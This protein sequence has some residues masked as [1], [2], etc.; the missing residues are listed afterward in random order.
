MTFPTSRQAEDVENL[1]ETLDSMLS[2]ML[3]KLDEW[4]AQVDLDSATGGRVARGNYQRL[5]AVRAFVAV[6]GTAGLAA[7]YQRRFPDLVGFDPEASWLVSKAAIDAFVTWFQA[8]WPK[9]TQGWP[10]WER[11]LAN[12]ELADV[13][14]PITGQ[15]KID[16]LA[17]LDAV[18]ATF[19]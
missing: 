4:R 6:K 15:A 12:G 11:Y 8:Q 18:L 14:A 9:T 5:T 7:A 19:D 2:A 13:T 16:F 17:N 10:A 3:D 1:A